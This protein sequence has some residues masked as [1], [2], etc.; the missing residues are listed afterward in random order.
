MSTTDPL[1]AGDR[2]VD[3]LCMEA[4]PEYGESGQRIAAARRCPDC[5]GRME[6]GVDASFRICQDCYD[7]YVDNAGR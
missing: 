6:P 1:K 5:G 4:R 7:A 2:S 3:A